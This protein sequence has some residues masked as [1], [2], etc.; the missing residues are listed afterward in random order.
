MAGNLH[1]RGATTRGQLRHAEDVRIAL[2]LVGIMAVLA[3]MAV[4][5]WSIVESWGWQKRVVG[6]AEPPCVG[7]SGRLS[8]RSRSNDFRVVC[9]EDG[10]LAVR[11]RM[12]FHTI[13][14]YRLCPDRDRFEITMTSTKLVVRQHSTGARLFVRGKTGQRLCHILEDQGWQVRHS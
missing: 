7:C 4:V 1:H 8:K 6:Q 3:T 13:E 9:F 11:Q 5:V 14:R 10:C 12:F 2:L